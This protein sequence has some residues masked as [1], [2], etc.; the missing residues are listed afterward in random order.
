MSQYADE[1][2]KG[3]DLKINYIR[4]STELRSLRKHLSDH[5]PIILEEKCSKSQ[6]TSPKNR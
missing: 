6:T 4:S 5:D 1:T 3:S 2:N